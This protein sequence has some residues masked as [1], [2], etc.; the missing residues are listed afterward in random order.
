M[1]GSSKG[2]TSKDGYSAV[3]EHALTLDTCLVEF[4]GVV[5]NWLQVV[6]I[7]DDRLDTE[8]GRRPI[9]NAPKRNSHIEHKRNPTPTSIMNIIFF[10]PSDDHRQKKTHHIKVRGSDVI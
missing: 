5:E 6:L 3:P 10:N 8:T 1:R 4:P 7:L 9:M 2:R